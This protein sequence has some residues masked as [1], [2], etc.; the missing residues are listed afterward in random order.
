LIVT[1]QLRSLYKLYVDGDKLQELQHAK[2]DKS[3]WLNAFTR[4]SLST[5]V[6]VAD[7]NGKYYFNILRLSV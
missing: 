1:L 2:W 3:Y 7:L 6:S 5:Y 4:N